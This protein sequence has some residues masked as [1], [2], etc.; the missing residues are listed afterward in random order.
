MWIKST[1]WSIIFLFLNMPLAFAQG[2]LTDENNF[3][4]NW[5]LS[6]QVGPSVVLTEIEGSY[7]EPTGSMRHNP[8]F[9]YDIRLGKMVLERFDTGIDFSQSFFTGYRNNPS[10]LNYMRYLFLENNVPSHLLTYPI[11]YSSAL[12]VVSVYAKYN[13]INFSSFEKGIIKLNLYTKVAAGISFISSELIYKEETNYQLTGLS[14]PLF[15][16]K[17]LEFPST[18]HFTLSPALGMNYQTSDRVF[19]TAE[20]GFSATNSDYVD[21][22]RN[23]SIPD[24]YPEYRAI[25]YQKVTAITMKIMFGATYFFNF[26]SHR[27]TRER[28]LPWYHHR[29]RSYYSKYQAQSP[30]KARQERLPFYK[31]RFKE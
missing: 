19:F 21:G 29:Y 23:F 27:P 16:S 7:S 9:S 12:T 24:N 4:T 1:Y 25:T 20:I 2:W 3:E 26:D 22:V 18:I 13:F 30:Q 8:G 28:Y 14:K 31:D 6:I 15:S 11:H 17:D 5:N 10:T